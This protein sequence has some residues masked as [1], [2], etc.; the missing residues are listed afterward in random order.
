MIVAVQ[1]STPP[2]PASFRGDGYQVKIGETL[3]LNKEL[4]LSDD[5]KVKSILWKSD[6]Q[7]VASVSASVMG[8]E[9]GLVQGVS[10]GKTSITATIQPVSGDPIT[11]TVPVTVTRT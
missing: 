7:Y 5:L 2:A 1:D 3:D 4:E 6:D 10:E 11:L 8:S 9:A